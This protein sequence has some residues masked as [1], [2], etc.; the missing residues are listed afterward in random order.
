M[1]GNCDKVIENKFEKVRVW[2]EGG[3]EGGREREI[4]R[5]REKSKRERDREER[6]RR[7]DLQQLIGLL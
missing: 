2:R 4:E 6:E 1:C 5:E 3:R 7:G